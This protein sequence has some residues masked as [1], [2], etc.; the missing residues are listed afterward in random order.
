MVDY[1]K[2]TIMDAFIYTLLAIAVLVFII[3]TWRVNRKE[4]KKLSNRLNR[5]FPHR[6][7]HKETGDPD[8]LKQD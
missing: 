8:D 7:S 6:E 2:A 1:Q 3:W 5:D 4:K